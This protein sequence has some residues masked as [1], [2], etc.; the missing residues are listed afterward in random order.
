[1]AK[2]HE[3]IW[4]FRMIA[5]QNLEYDLRN[6]L[7]CKN[8]CFRRDGYVPIG[9]QDIINQRDRAVVKC[10][11]DTVVNDY[12]PFYFSVRTP[13]LYNIHTGHGVSSFPQSNIVY[14]CCKLVDL[15]TEGFQWCYTEG[16]AAKKITKFFNDLDSFDRLDWHSIKTTDFRD[17]NADGDEDRVRKKHSEFLVKDHVPTKYIKTIVVY[18]DQKKQ[19]VEKILESL[20][21]NIPVNVNPNNK[22]YF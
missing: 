1:M 14:L 21:L 3:K 20:H 18:S 16:N 10:Y 17:D 22:F 8:N 15:A 5:I 9:S 7:Y 4:V 13:M 6:G 19:E 11:P 12:V 2:E